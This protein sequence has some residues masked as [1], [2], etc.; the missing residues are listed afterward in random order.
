MNVYYNIYMLALNF[1]ELKLDGVE[2]PRW[3]LS[4]SHVL[5]I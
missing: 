1:S 3:F 2:S 5:A 4:V